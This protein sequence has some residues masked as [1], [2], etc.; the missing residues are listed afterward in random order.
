[1]PELPEVEHVVRALRRVILDRRII[2]T[3]IR[4]PKLILPSSSSVFNRNLKGA[5][6]TG[7]GRRGKFILIEI[8]SGRALP[9][10]RATTPRRRRELQKPAR[11]QGLVLV[12]HLRMTGKF[13]YLTPD[14]ALPKHAHAI[15]YL[16]N[17]RRLVFCDQRKFGVMKLVKR[18]ALSTTK[19]IS[20]LAP[21]PF[22][23]DFSLAYLKATLARSRRA[24][25]TL[26]LDQTKI[27]GLGN[28]YA[29]EALFRAGVSP[30]KE[31]ASLS[32]KRVARLHQAIL[33]VLSDAISDSS[34][35]RVDLEQ[36]NGFSYGEAFERFWQVY[37]R[38]G[39]PC[40]NCGGR[41]RRIAHGG[42]STYWCPKCQRR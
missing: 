16:E 10:G 25:K 7:V 13:L 28:I 22:G 9:H 24:L 19:G 15:F 6:I 34:T 3:E 26:L 36:P 32:S 40:V 37:E 14:D 17:D 11:Q 21:E 39:E 30:F 42:R 20:E 41:I 4:L 5:T 38:E 29:A 8:E 1:M 23:E 35:S 2:A 18:T 33:D 12:V 27:L 31:A